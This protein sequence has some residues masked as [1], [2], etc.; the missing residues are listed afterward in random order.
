MSELPSPDLSFIQVEMTGPPDQ[1]SRLV[2]ALGGEGEI[3]YDSPSAPDDRGHVSRLVQV[4]TH[5]A[6]Q[7][8]SVPAREAAVTVQTVLDLDTASWPGLPEAAA[9]RHIE[10]ATAAALQDLPG[11]SQARSRVI[12]VL[13][14]PAA[15]DQEDG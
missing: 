1:V 9:V 4:V 10:D 6:G 13:P 11:A 7:A 5:E 15:P 3:I 14:L 12:A 8:P 2:A